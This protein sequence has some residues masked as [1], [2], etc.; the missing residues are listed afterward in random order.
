[1]NLFNL[2]EEEEARLRAE[3]AASLDSDMAKIRKRLDDQL[4]KDIAA[5]IRD[6]EGNWLQVDSDDEEE[7]FGDDEDYEDEDDYESESE[8]E[9]DE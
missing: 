5:G 1:M 3:A 2:Y 6:A 4:Q 8:S 9:E 7:D